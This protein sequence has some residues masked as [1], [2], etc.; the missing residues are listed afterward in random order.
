MNVSWALLR[1]PR[2]HNVCWHSPDLHMHK[3]TSRRLDFIKTSKYSNK[4]RGQ[5]GDIY[6]ESSKLVKSQT[7]AEYVSKLDFSEV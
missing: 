2:S 7:E 4:R 5:L 1:I 3:Y 6:G